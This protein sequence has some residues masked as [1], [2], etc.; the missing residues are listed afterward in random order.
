MKIVTITT[1]SK[2][3]LDFSV[4]DDV[5]PKTLINN[6]KSEGI[7][8]EDNN[9]ITAINPDY[10]ETIEIEPDKAESD[11][12][13]KDAFQAIISSVHS[14]GGSTSIDSKGNLVLIGGKAYG[15]IPAQTINDYHKKKGYTYL[16]I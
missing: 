10:I 12:K 11:L 8:L 1:I 14:L 16:N 6:I 2:R 3:K 7:I 5:C 15:H 13:D 4:K 9:K